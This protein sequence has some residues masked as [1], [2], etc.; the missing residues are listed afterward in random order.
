VLVKRSINKKSEKEP[1][2]EEFVIVTDEVENRG[3]I[4]MV[5]S[6][7]RCKD[8]NLI[9]NFENSQNRSRSDYHVSIVPL[10]MG[11]SLYLPSL[12]MKLRL[13]LRNRL[14]Q[15]ILETNALF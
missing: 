7:H 6:L 5:S 1:L 12:S 9:L 4:K 13:F 14:I 15:Q 3:N 11:L 2:F 10:V 8:K